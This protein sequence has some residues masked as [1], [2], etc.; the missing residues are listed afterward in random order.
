M[1]TQYAQYLKK[2][3][4]LKFPSAS[5]LAGDKKPSIRKGQRNKPLIPLSYS[6]WARIGLSVFHHLAICRLV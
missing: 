3:K 2:N 1:V 4:D 5:V 6:R